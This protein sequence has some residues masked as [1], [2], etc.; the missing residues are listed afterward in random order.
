VVSHIS[1]RRVFVDELDL[2]LL[3]VI[4]NDGIL[5][6]AEELSKRLSHTAHRVSLSEISNRLEQLASSNILTSHAE[7]NSLW[8]SLESSCRPTPFIDFVEITNMCPA[9][10]IMCRAGQGFM[11]RP[12]GL[13][14]MS[15]FERILTMIEPRLDSKPLILHNAGEPFLHPQLASMV[16]LAAKGN[17]PTEISTNAGLLTLDGYQKLCGAG[18]ARIVIALDGTDVETLSAIRGPGACPQKAFVN[19]DDILNYR[20]TH[21]STSPTIVIQMVKMRANAHQHKRFLERYGDLGLPGV[22]AFLKPVEAPSDSPLLM[23][24]TRPP[25]HFCSAPWQTL[26]IYWDGNVIPCCYDLNASLCVGNVNHQTLTEIWEGDAIADLRER[27]K[28]NKCMPN[29]LC[30]ICH[31]RPDRYQMPDLNAIP[32]VPDGWY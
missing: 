8:L 22:S 9:T 11:E 10:C 27:I 13:M 19:I 24:G 5:L 4:A 15:L 25:Q 17:V 20:A 12:K 31:N 21:Q 18:I 32:E 3:R 7:D 29:D 2:A 16:S 1:R 26:G 6:T 23:P 14:S 28:T 30:A